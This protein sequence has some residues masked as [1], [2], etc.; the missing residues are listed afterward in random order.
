MSYQAEAVR[1]FNYPYEAI[2]EVLANAVYHRN[3]ET[4]EPIEIRIHPDR[5]HVSYH[6][7]PDAEQVLQAHVYAL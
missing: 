6:Y 7:G 2:E 5:I 3:Y 4:N 1:F